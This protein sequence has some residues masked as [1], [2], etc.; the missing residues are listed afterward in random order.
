MRRLSSV[1]LLFTVLFFC[2]LTSCSKK[3]IIVTDGFGGDIGELSVNE[4]FEIDDS[5]TLVYE[6]GYYLSEKCG[7]G[8]DIRRLSDAERVIY[9]VYTL[10]GEVNNGGFA[11]YFYNSSGD[12]GYE[13]EAA[14]QK[15]GA[16]ETAA[17]CAKAVAV[18]GTAYPQDR[19]K[20][21]DIMMSEDNVHFSDI[22]SECDSNFFEYPEDTA[23]MMYRFIMENRKGFS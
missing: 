5:Y 12:F 2:I 13:L 1:L 21:Q 17:I 9:V 15:I 23:D 19:A 10:E 4:I 18:F 3:S 6:M 7:F 11:Q 8:D 14:F 20:R 16:S 22:W